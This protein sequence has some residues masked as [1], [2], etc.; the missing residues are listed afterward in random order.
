M[1]TDSIRLVNGGIDDETFSII[2][3]IMCRK[4]AERGMVQG[5]IP[6]RLSWMDPA[7]ACTYEI[8]D[9]TEGMVVLAGNR[10]GFLSGVGRILLDGSFTQT[11]FKPGPFRG[12]FTNRHE[13]LGTYFATHFGNYY[14]TAPMDELRRLLE[15]LALYGQNYLPVWFDMHHYTG[16]DDPNAVAFA[17]RVS[18]MLTLARRVGMKIDIGGLSNEAFSTT[19]DPLK[20]QW[21]AQNGYKHGLSHYHVEICPHAPGGMEW[22]LQNRRDMLELFRDLHPDFMSFSIYDQG[23]CTCEKCAPYGAKT[24]LDLTMQ[25]HELVKEYW[26]DTKLMLSA[27]LLGEPVDGEWEYWYDELSKPKYKD[28]EYIKGLSTAFYQIHPRVLK[29]EMLGDKKFL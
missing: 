13:L 20:A 29:G 10:S 1:R 15:D 3:G 23:G 16:A 27:W 6:I 21:H 24:Y 26:P 7:F 12:M 4:L 14:V 11:G 5:G 2:D 25:L 18:A 17:R 8:A 19:P 22:I 28:I 9:S